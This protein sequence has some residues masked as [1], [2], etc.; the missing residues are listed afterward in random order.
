MTAASLR[1]LLVDSAPAAAVELS[2]VVS[3]QPDMTVVGIASTG[4]EGL[5]HAA[6]LAPDIVL[7]DMRLADMDGVHATWLISS[8]H[9][10]AAVIILTAELR[11]EDMDRV[12]MA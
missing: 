3:E 9:P 5:Q 8:R 6:D 12:L 7:V 10:A 11:P 4:Q 2:Q 1:I